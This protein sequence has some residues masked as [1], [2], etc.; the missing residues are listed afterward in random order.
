[1]VLEEAGAPDAGASPTLPR[2]VERC[3][4]ARPQDAASYER[5]KRALDVVLVL[6]TSPIWLPLLGVV[7]IVARLSSLQQAVFYCQMRT[8]RG[9]CRF[10]M[11]KFRTMITREDSISEGGLVPDVYQGP[12]RP[13]KE[14][15]NPRITPFGRALRRTSLDEL[16]Q[17]L[18]VLRGDMSLVGPRPTS[19]PPETYGPGE[20]RRLDVPQGLTGLWQVL[21]RGETDF[22]QWVAYD[23]EYSRRRGL[24]LDMKILLRTVPAVLR[25]RG[26]C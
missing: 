12:W 18:N 26:A 3:A 16:P 19:F 7:A 1:M 11:Y 14:E 15:M 21:A 23:V 10:G 6:A 9:G 24:L 4:L 8:G 22:D 25:Q 2:W 17:L 13:V 20:H 5:T